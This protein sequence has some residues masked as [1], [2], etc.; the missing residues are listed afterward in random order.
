MENIPPRLLLHVL[1]HLP[2]DDWLRVANLCR[3]LRR[4]LARSQ[5]AKRLV[6][7]ALQWEDAPL[8]RTLLLDR[9]WP[10]DD[11]IFGGFVRVCR[12]GQTSLICEILQTERFLD[13]IPLITRLAVLEAW[14]QAMRAK[15]AATLYGML[16]LGWGEND[17]AEAELICAQQ[18][19]GAELAPVRAG[20]DIETETLTADEEAM[21]LTKGG[22]P[23]APLRFGNLVTKQHGGLSGAPFA[24][25]GR[26]IVVHRNPATGE[27]SGPHRLDDSDYREPALGWEVMA[28]PR[29]KKGPWAIYRPPFRNYYDTPP[30]LGGGQT[31]DG[32]D[33]AAPG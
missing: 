32:G 8:L 18:G 14:P 2:E 20:V 33:L 7:V 15:N 9:K 25:G 11:A 12:R 23:P 22:D 28:D 29:R 10:M 31:L 30:R 27:F 16:R 1:R 17:R 13:A 4:R 24:W 19:Y 3:T 5:I 26:G 6:S 21:L